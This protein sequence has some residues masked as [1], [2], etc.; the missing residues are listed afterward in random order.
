MK[1]NEWVRERRGEEREGD[2]GRQRDY[3]EM[4]EDESV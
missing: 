4:R 2:T 3:D 1:V